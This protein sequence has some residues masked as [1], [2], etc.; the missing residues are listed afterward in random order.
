[1][2]PIIGTKNQDPCWWLVA[3]YVLQILIAMEWELPK[4]I[5]KTGLKSNA[6]YCV[7]NWTSTCV[8]FCAEVVSTAT[9]IADK[10]M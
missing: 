8:H 7:F 10:F 1:M 4:I 5:V 3:I 9:L 2:S 6:N